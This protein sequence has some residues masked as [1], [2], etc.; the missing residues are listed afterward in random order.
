[1]NAPKK[2]FSPLAVGKYGKL[3]KKSTHPRHQVKVGKRGLVARRV[4]SLGAL[5]S[6]QTKKILPA[7]NSQETHFLNQDEK[8]KWS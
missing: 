6:L 2:I 5:R 3:T 7:E 1:V 8:E 4:R